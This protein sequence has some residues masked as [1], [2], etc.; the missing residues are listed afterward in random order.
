MTNK[1]K[2]INVLR[3]IGVDFIQADKHNINED[4]DIIILKNDYFDCEEDS[5]ILQFDSE[6]GKYF[7]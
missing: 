7:E 6:T 5:F 1:E 3:E 2:L 4:I